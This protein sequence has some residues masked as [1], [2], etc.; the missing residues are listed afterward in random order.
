LSSVDLAR[1][2]GLME[3]YQSLPP[4]QREATWQV[5]YDTT[6][7]GQWPATT[8][9]VMCSSA[10]VQTFNADSIGAA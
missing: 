4:P 2:K 5:T 1:Y 7:A 9:V 10:P 3:A 8:G 6:T